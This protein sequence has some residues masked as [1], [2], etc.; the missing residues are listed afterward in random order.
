[1]CNAS[2]NFVGWSGVRKMCKAIR[3]FDKHIDL[4]LVNLQR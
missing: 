2:D 3:H 4:L 1:M